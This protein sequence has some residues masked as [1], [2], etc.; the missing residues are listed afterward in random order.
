MLHRFRKSF[1]LRACY[2][3]CSREHQESIDRVLSRL[4]HWTLCR[5]LLRKERNLAWWWK[6]LVRGPRNPQIAVRCRQLAR[7]A[8]R[9]CARLRQTADSSGPAESRRH[10]PGYRR[11]R[12]DNR[13]EACIG[14]DSGVFSYLSWQNRLLFLTK[15]RLFDIGMYCLQER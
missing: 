14:P 11:I 9:S 13:T 3:P 12:P 5:C 15:L 4:V 10:K 7:R 2:S 1:A 6:W 8:G